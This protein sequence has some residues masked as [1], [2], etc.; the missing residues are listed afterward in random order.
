MQQ[1][2]HD[3]VKVTNYNFWGTASFQLFQDEFCI[4]LRYMPAAIREVH[5][6]RN[7]PPNIDAAVML[8]HVV[9]GHYDV[10]YSIGMMSQADAYEQLL[11]E[12]AGECAAFCKVVSCMVI[13]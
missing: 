2:D 1:R 9:G 12:H 11:A 10:P 3:F 5:R 6:S 7:F 13:Y 8:N 4:M